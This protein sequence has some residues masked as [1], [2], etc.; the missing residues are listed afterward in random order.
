MA[1]ALLLLVTLL[2]PVI[3]R[4]ADLQSRYKDIQERMAEQKEKIGEALG[5]ESSILSEIEEMNRKLALTE[6]ELKRQRRALRRTES[7]IRD[8]NGR[9]ANIDNRLATRKNWIKRK[10][11]VMQ[12]FG[13]SGDL[14][15]LLLS[16]RDASQ[17]MRVWR[18][19]ESIA[20]Y[21]NRVLDEYRHDLKEL[22]AEKARLKTLKSNLLLKTGRVAAEEKELAEQRSEKE[23]LLSSVRHEKDAHR[24]M[25]ME[26]QEAS[27][28]LLDI[29]RE[30][31]RKDT[32]AGRG[33][34]HLKGKLHWPVNGRV[35]IPYGPQKDPQF[36]TPVFR[37]G[38]HIKTASDAD[39]RAIYGGK[40][41]FSDWFKGYGQLIIVNHGGGYNSLYGNLSQIFSHAG[42]II[43]SNQ[44]IGKVGTSGILN[45]P[46]L[47]FE[48]RYK[49]K[50]LDP[51]QWL[52]NK[53]R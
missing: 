23:G 8:T 43:K 35:A 7:E 3:S 53:R 52:L 33:F 20:A 9:I 45:A 13:Y 25:L 49:G 44:V 11:R 12:R 31:Y 29:I 18:D 39:A 38:I 47:Y 19:L 48:I 34:S 5:R 16:A 50:P 4:A 32:Y 42:D 28:K 2:S 15:M 6:K 17:M 10:L 21:D 1:V 41:I 24:K 46:G 30:S 51:T 40:V 22:K 36:D 14:L 26:L 27:R 37:N